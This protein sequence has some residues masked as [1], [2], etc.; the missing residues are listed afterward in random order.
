MGDVH[1]DLSEHVPVQKVSDRMH[2]AKREGV[3]R[4][5]NFIVDG[6]LKIEAAGDSWS[7]F[8]SSFYGAMASA[9]M[10]EYEENPD[11]HFSVAYDFVDGYFLGQELA[12]IKR[13]VDEHD[14]R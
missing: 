13:F 10:E 7:A 1:P 4:G 8:M 9:S 3:G 5:V 11:E 2:V 12:G 14:L 6:R